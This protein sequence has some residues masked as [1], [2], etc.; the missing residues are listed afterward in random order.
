[1]D[2]SRNEVT[3]NA[4]ETLDRIHEKVNLSLVVYMTNRERV[5]NGLPID[6][7]G[8]G[9]VPII[10]SGIELV[11]ADLR[12]VNFRGVVLDRALLNRSDMTGADMTYVS[13]EDA[14][15]VGVH[16]YEAKMDYAKFKGSSFRLADM[17]YASLIGSDMRRTD[18]TGVRLRS[19]DL[20]HTDFS[21][22]DLSGAMISASGIVEAELVR[23]RRRPTDKSIPGWRLNENGRLYNYLNEISDDTP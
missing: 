9:T 22:A 6:L 17:R 7:M 5:S 16:L 3:L 4:L 14:D 2:G 19:A 12:G 18:C 13:A 23:A 15:F 20:D 11:E 10:L 1:M 8:D 21:D